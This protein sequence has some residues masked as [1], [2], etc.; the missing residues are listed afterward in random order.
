MIEKIVIHQK[1]KIYTVDITGLAAA[2]EFLD[3]IEEKVNLKLIVE[4]P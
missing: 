3:L 2:I 1:E 4:E